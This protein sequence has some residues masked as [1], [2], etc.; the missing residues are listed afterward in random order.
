[1]TLSLSSRRR[2]EGWGEEASIKITAKQ[3]IPY[4]R[5][6]DVFLKFPL[7]PSLSPLVPRGERGFALL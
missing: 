4:G 1:M 3:W 5:K 6:I 7:S 2:R